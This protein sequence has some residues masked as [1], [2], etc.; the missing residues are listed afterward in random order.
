VIGARLYED[1]K[2]GTPQQTDQRKA[3]NPIFLIC[4]GGRLFMTLDAS[5]E[6]RKFH[7][8]A[9]PLIDDQLITPRLLLH[10]ETDAN[11]VL[12]VSDYASVPKMLEF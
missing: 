5:D 6:Y 7:D 3:M 4:G 8:W 11:I 1:A 12:T 2:Y 10:A 9:I